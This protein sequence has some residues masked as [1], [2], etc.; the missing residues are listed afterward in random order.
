[1]NRL[2]C[3]AVEAL[4][5]GYLD[6]NLN[7]RD[8]ALCEA[9]LTGC[10]AC[11]DVVAGL[12]RLPA[13]LSTWQVPPADLPG[14]EQLAARIIHRHEPGVPLALRWAFGAAV[15]VVA[16]GWWAAR[17]PSRPADE[18]RHPEAAAVQRHT[19]EAAEAAPR[20]ARAGR[21]GFP[22]TGGVSHHP[23]SLLQRT[24]RADPQWRGEEAGVGPGVR[25]GTSRSGSVR[26]A[27]ARLGRR[28]RE[29]PPP[30]R[31]A[32]A[33][34]DAASDKIMAEAGGSAGED[35]RIVAISGDSAATVVRIDDDFE[36]G[37]QVFIAPREA[38]VR[39]DER[40]G[41]S[42]GNG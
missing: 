20:V 14:G 36:R 19:P 30:G 16:A 3:A 34:G 21:H 24:A 28:G 10:A 5:P 6:S 27:A 23:D 17:P 42:G 22:G 9:H 31:A 26:I 25:T 4:L 15:F 40:S 39:V 18:N 13:A 35:R 8:Q 29:T 33:A 7:E 32:P 38:A 37:R 11:R 41:P 1:M 12:R 2:R